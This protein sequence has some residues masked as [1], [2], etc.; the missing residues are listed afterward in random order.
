MRF[1]HFFVDRP[2][3]ATVLSAILLIVG[4]IAY[5]TLPVAQYPEVTP[6]TVVVRASYPGA[7]AETVAA[8]VATPL[9]QQINGVEDMLYMSSYS[10]GD[11]SMALTITFK[12]GTDL[13]KAQVLVQNRVAIA[14]PRLPDEV[15]RLG[16]TTLKS[17]PDLM[18]V[19]HMLSP[20]GSYDQLYVSNYARNYVRDVLMRLD[21]VGD[22]II[23]GERQYSLRVWLDPE[24]LAS[25]GLTSAEVVRAIQEQ[26]VQVS[27]GALG[28]E[29]TPGEA[30]F[31]MTVTTQG[32][33]EDPRQFRQIIVQATRDGRLVRLQDVARIELGAQDYV[34]NSYLNGKPAVALAI[35][36]RPGTNALAAADQ[37]IHTMEQLKAN[38]PPGIAYQ[39]VYNPTEFIAESVNEVYKTLFEATA[40]VVLVVIVFLQSWRTA[41]IPI[42]AIPVSLVG[43]FAVMAALGFSINTLT[44]FGLVLAIGI[45]VDDAIV[46]VE[47][48]ERNI[49]M[50]MSPRDAA[51]E[52]MDE[53][54][55]ALV[56]IALVLVAVFVPTAFIPG[57]SGQFYR[58]FALTIAVSTAISAFNS[59]TL[60]PALAAW[61]LKPHSHEPPKNVLVRAG[62][63]AAGRFNRG[64]DATSRGYARAVGAVARHKLIVLPVYV[65]LLAG[66]VWIANHVPRGFIPTLDQG[67]AIVVVQLP[68]GSSLS[69]TD[70]VVQRAS[71]L[72]QETPGVLDAVAFAGFSGATFTNATNSAAIFARFKPFDE[73]VKE[74]DS[75]S[76]IIGNLFG[77]MQQIEEAFIIA[78]PP[79]PVRGLGNSGGFKLQIQNRTGDD[80]RGILAVAYQM[81]GKAQQNPNLSGVFTTFS[82]NS[83]QVYLEI[84][85]QK[86]SIL[87][88]PIPNIFETLRINLGTAYVNDFNAFGRVYQ[89]RAQ[90][91]QRFRI[92]QEDINRLRVRSSTGALVPLG[93]LVEMREVSG[94]DLIQRYNMFTSVA[95]QGNAAPGVSSGTALDVMEDLARQSLSPGMGYEWTELAFQERQTGNTAVFI[96]ALSVLFVFLVLAAQYES[97]SLPVAIILIVPMSV[98]SALI[99]VMIRGQDNNILT[100]IG[101]VVLVGLAA[102]NAILIVEF[103]KQAEEEGKAPVEAVIEAC[104]LRLRPILMTAFAF[105]LGVLPLAIATGPGAE[106]RQALGTAVFAGMLGVTF[107]GLF[108]TPVFYVAMRLLV[109]RFTRR[110]PAVPGHAA[111]ARPSPAE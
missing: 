62:K 60:S 25:F 11:G 42:V 52:T 64:F 61:L 47:N 21:G 84:D 32:R 15:R 98:L 103:A 9:E 5:T 89:V 75:A 79:P 70:A 95:L 48:V 12:L 38:F 39:I 43:T 55:T 26:N 69:R 40:L 14:T 50:G 1:A 97:W 67:Y 54:G 58:Q 78:I 86:A 13:D 83:P 110:R 76:K 23:F 28:Q 100:Q 51:H 56:A 31:Q 88:V 81:M 3:F 7:D 109:M 35:F 82:A 37:I 93:T 66:T 36:Q 105:I 77:R 72:I 91:D 49:A 104:R 87:N 29:P 94:P 8:T 41:I 101:L 2:I 68:D 34:T 96:F 65:G 22:L 4:G 111:D 57:I 24:R 27:G 90:A 10:T 30:A 108:L 85:R 71:K 106:M 59:L 99:G 20:D 53:V 17:S 6:P 107:F 45:V 102:K 46:V 73:R 18:M 92:D 19:V 63:A 80:V 33:F 16:V 44:L 74:G